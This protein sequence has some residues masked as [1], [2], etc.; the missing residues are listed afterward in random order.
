M[1]DDSGKAVL[2]EMLNRKYYENYSEVDTNEV[3][4]LILSAIDA[5]AKLNDNDLNQAIEVLSK[6][7]SNMKIRAKALEALEK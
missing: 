7:D 2:L 6:E 4:N 3:K 1:S 5:S